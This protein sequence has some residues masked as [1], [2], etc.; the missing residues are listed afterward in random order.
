MLDT[1]SFKTVA[2]LDKAYAEHLESMKTGGFIKEGTP[3]FVSFMGAWIEA[4]K[5]LEESL[6]KPREK[7][8]RTL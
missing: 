5:D 3:E 1:F 6:S 2:E 7:N 8:Y 4:V